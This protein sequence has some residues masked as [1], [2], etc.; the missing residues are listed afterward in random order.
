MVMSVAEISAQRDPVLRN[1]WI[2]QRYHEL[3]VQLRDK[4]MA[5]DATWCAFAVWASKTA[6][7]TIRGDELPSLVRELLTTDDAAQG[8]IHR[9]NAGL[10]GWLVARLGHRHLF[11]VVDAVNDHVAASIAGGNLLV[12][13]ELAPLFTLLAGASPAAL[14]P[15]LASLAAQGVDVTAIRTAFTGYQRALHT[16]A[17]RP[18]LVL[19]ANILAVSH[20][21]ERLQPAIATAL[22][23]AVHDLF[24]ETLDQDVT[25]HIPTARARRTFDTLVADVGGVL[26][27]ACQ[28]ALTKVMLRLITADETFALDRNVPPLADGLYPPLL[29]DLTGTEAEIVFS[30][31]DRTLGLGAPTGADDWAVID[32]R[33]NYIVTLFRS[34][35]RHPALLSPP[36]SDVQ[37]A[38][39][40]DGRLPEGSL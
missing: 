3:A 21:Q 24:V 11:R 18:T 7:A 37:L 15:E 28:T 36:F 19:G 27:R 23:A 26:E 17:E 2:T 16:P 20:E 22:N 31:W 8:A 30:R 14:E 25:R 1:L 35:Q 5:D 32:Q 38:A 39:L 12:F 10:E 9:F 33:M 6:G 40:A 13:S 29:S 4:G 34:R